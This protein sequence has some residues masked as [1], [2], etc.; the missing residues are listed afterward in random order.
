MLLRD[1]IV[2]DV[3][4]YFD[5]VDISRIL[6][7][8]KTLNALVKLHVRVIKDVYKSKYAEFKGLREINFTDEAR[9]H[10]LPPDVSMP[11]I[12]SN[13]KEIV[14]TNHITSADFINSLPNSVTNID[15]YQID[16]L[17]CVIF[18]PNLRYL[19]MSEMQLSI[20]D[21]DKLPR[22]LEYYKQSSNRQVKLVRAIDGNKF[23]AED[24]GMI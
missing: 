8:C 4:K 16:D 17:F 1:V 24:H 15:L 3:C 14:D 21:L 13:I 6:C 20:S 2:K 18:P 7:V 9:I 5:E 11:I 22:T 23:V 10:T 12:T 19:S